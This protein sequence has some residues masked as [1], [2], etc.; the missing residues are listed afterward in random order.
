MILFDKVRKTEEQLVKSICKLLDNFTAKLKQATCD[1]TSWWAVYGKVGN[2]VEE[3]GIRCGDC[4][5]EIMNG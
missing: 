4:R 2:K 3:V 1:H 5:K